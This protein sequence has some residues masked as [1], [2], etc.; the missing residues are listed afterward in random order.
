MGRTVL[1]A[2]GASH[3]QTCV[4]LLSTAATVR[5]KAPTVSHHVEPQSTSYFPL[6]CLLLQENLPTCA[7]KGNFCFFNESGQ[8]G[9][10]EF[11]LFFALS[12]S[13]D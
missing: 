3:H 12:C 6:L 10:G 7:P 8:H 13:L 2:R 5:T 9:T 1:P 4:Q 11:S